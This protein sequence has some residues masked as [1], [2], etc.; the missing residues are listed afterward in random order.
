MLKASILRKSI[1]GD[2]SVKSQ[3]FMKSK[4]NNPDKE[5]PINAVQKVLNEKKASSNLTPYLLL[6]ALSFHGL[7]E[8]IALGLQSDYKSTISL[9]LAILAHKWAEALT[10]GVSFTKAET[11]KS[12]FIKMITI[13]AVFT[14]FG[15]GIGMVLGMCPIWVNSTFMSLSV[16]TF[17]YIGG[18]EIVVEEFSITRF[19]W[20][21]F[22]MYIVG[23][24][25]IA[26]LTIWEVAGGNH[27]HDG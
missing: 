7:F 13:F 26:G 12:M 6:L 4:I 9:L 23:G 14:P 2:E 10:L 18:S 24:G 27:S 17:L 1:V 22:L 15:V 16:G 25:F 20:A 5:D 8:G 11:E 19:K 21:K 3:V